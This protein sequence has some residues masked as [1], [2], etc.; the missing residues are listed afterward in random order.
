MSNTEIVSL[1]D[2]SVYFNESP[3][4][5]DVSFSINQDDF[6]AII[7]PN[8]SGKTTL[9]KAILGLI[10]PDKGEVKVFGKSPE[11]G[12]KS[13]GYLPQ[14]TFFDLNFP[15]SVFDVVL[16][17]RYKGI[18]KSYSRE[19]S[20]AVIQTLETVGMLEFR[21]RQIGKLS[22]GQMQ[23]VF[24]ARAIAREPRLLLLDEPT[25]SIDPEMQNS[26]YALLSQLKKR[27]AIVLVSHDIG[28]V[29][30]HVDKVICVNRKLF[31]HGPTETAAKSIEEL[32]HCPIDLV[33]HG[34][35]HRVF[36]IH[37]KE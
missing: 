12:R 20:D 8:G 11:G 21:D 18:G 1:R 15:I 35:P 30:A 36:G 13:I 14:S 37:G 33:A 32:Y 24:L 5:E 23:R 19:D 10:K 31:Y 26:F 3:I 34:V 22:G 7:G 16:T 2:V 9:L 25:A 4:L 28:V 6:L 27:M 17:G 29:F